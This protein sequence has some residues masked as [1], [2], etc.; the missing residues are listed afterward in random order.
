MNAKALVP[1]EFLKL[2]GLLLDELKNYDLDPI[3]RKLHRLLNDELTEKLAAIDRRASFTGYKTAK[4]AT[5]GREEKRKAYLNQAEV[6]LDW[7]S[8]E[9]VP[10]GSNLKIE[11]EM[12]VLHGHDT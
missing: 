2:T 4:P 3:T 9:E 6:H 1:V 11:T 12:E 7:R 5:S 10:Y 8:Q